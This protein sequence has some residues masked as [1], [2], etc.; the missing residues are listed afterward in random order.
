MREL[1]NGVPTASGALTG[2]E[3]FGN[4]G[5]AGGQASQLKDISNFINGQ[6]AQLNWLIGGDFGRNLWQRG[7]SVI[8]TG[9]ALQYT[10]DRWWLE[11]PA[12]TNG[13]VEQVGEQ[14]TISRTAGSGQLTFGQVLTTGNSLP[15]VGQTVEFSGQLT[16]VPVGLEIFI[17]WGTGENQSASAFAAGSWTGYQESV[18]EVG[19]A[20]RFSVTAA[21]PI[22]TSQVGVGLRWTDDGALVVGSCQ[23]VIG[24]SEKFLWRLQE[25]E[26]NL[27]L[28]YFWRLGGAANLFLAGFAPQN[29]VEWA[30]VKFPVAMRASPT[31]SFDS[32]NWEWNIGG[33]T[34][35]I[36]TLTL[37]AVSSEMAT[38][39]D[40]AANSSLG[41]AILVATAS[42]GHF[43][44]NAEL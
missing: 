26:T 44:F 20:G 24:S 23:L 15:L 17:G 32:T 14:A 29:N 27:Q 42:G 38:V 1:T 5:V 8:V 31:A 41:G 22:G 39:G 4:D 2:E 10:A 21:L 6:L 30:T 37:A 3:F 33:T 12:S 19:D 25:E 11:V 7:T 35:A 16:E 34:V 36:G 9:A 40:S 28:A 13:K 18:S 43:D